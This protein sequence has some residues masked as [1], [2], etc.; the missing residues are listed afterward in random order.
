MEIMCGGVGSFGET[1]PQVVIRENRLMLTLLQKRDQG[2][3]RHS[4]HPNHIDHRQ[5]RIAPVSVS[6]GPQSIEIQ[7]GAP[8]FLARRDAL[9]RGSCP[10]PVIGSKSPASVVEWMPESGFCVCGPS[11]K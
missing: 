11:D 1:R 6:D 5:R 8:R 10:Q 2:L 3:A 4:W 7:K 9:R